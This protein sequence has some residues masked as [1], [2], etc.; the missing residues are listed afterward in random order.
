MKS[1]KYF[2]NTKL[3]SPLNLLENDWFKNSEELY[4]K[5]ILEK[6][7][8][9]YFCELYYFYEQGLLFDFLLL[10][11]PTKKTLTKD[12]NISYNTYMKS[13]EMNGN[14]I[15]EINDKNGINLSS[16]HRESEFDISD[17]KQ[18]FFEFKNNNNKKAPSLVTSHLK[19][20]L[21]GKKSVEF[22]NQNTSKKA[23]GFSNKNKKVMIKK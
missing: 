22:S 2:I 9:E 4:L 10:D 7:L 16:S 15:I 3:Y 13:F 1:Q 21:E 14:K 11:I 12:N 18:N 6:H 23:V 5:D 17:Q 8:D 19:K 20:K